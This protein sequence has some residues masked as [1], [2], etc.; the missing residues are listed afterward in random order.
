MNLRETLKK[1]GR[2]VRNS[3]PGEYRGT[4]GGGEGQRCVCG[5]EE[6]Q[7]CKVSNETPVFVGRVCL[8]GF[9]GNKVREEPVPRGRRGGIRHA[10]LQAR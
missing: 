10:K 2:K 6:D 8:P 3:S 5:G 4:G 1:F 7:A 9:R